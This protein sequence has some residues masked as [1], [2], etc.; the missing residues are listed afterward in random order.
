MARVK[1]GT[2]A[3]KRRKK[4]LKAVKGFMWSR[5]TKYR[6]A[7]EALLHSRTN[8]FTGRKLKKRNFRRLWQ[9]QINAA[10][11]EQGLSYS[12]FIDAL[13]KSNVELDRKVLS[14]IARNHP[15]VFQTIVK[16]VA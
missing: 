8:M 16:L 5:K 13:N 15:E 4:T 7:K 6:A 11:R 12:K 14:E 1:R 2:T 9:V 10:V 3:S